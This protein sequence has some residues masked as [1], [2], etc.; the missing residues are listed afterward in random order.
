MSITILLIITTVIISYLSFNNSSLREILIFSPYQYINNKKWWLVVS[1]GFIHADYL[2]LFFNMYVLYA[3]GF[4]V[5]NQFSELNTLGYLYFLILYL[6]AMIFATLPS[7][8][9]HRNNPSYRSLGASGA[10]SAVVF[11]FI[12]LAPTAQMGLIILPGLYIPAFLFGLLYLLA[13]NYMSKKGGSNIAH[14]AHIAGAIFGILFVGF[15]DYKLYINFIESIAN[16][17]GIS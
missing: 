5:E 11:V 4:N 3:F 1:H 2:H 15:F 6:G 7:I 9:K 14:D 10:V 16:Y 17:I 8:I 12:I 13:E